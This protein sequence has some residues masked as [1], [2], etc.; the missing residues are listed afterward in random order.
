MSPSLTV[1]PLM[2]VLL[3]FIF[4]LGCYLTPLLAGLLPSG[5][6][7]GASVPSSTSLDPSSKGGPTATSKGSVPSSSGALPNVDKSEAK[8]ERRTVS[9]RG[10]GV[11]RL[12][13]EQREE[14]VYLP[15]TFICPENG[16]RYAIRQVPGDGGCLF[17]A[18][19][20]AM[21]F[22]K[23]RKH[24]AFD[25]KTRHMS[26]KLR[27]LSVL[28]LK[29][30][31][32]SL[33]IE[34]GECTT[35]S[36]LLRI[37]SEHYNMSQAEYCEQMLLSSS[38]GG[39]PEIVALCNHLQRPIYVFELCRHD[40]GVGGNSEIEQCPENACKLFDL[41]ICG[42]FGSP[43]FDDEKPLKILCADGRFPNSLDVDE[44]K[45]G[46]HF[47]ALETIE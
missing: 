6:L 19:T 40:N 29:R 24:V 31:D 9:R 38:W 28:L 20:V 32:V 26:D 46:D 2:R 3:V 25:E 45:P 23:T 44:T 12:G 10:I 42:K 16:E 34:N 18:L 15:G 37:V 27:K 5:V 7:L 8:Q 1:R 11:S 13:Q 35:S 41:R 47:L 43:Q 30:R 21:I 4:T 17:H 36:D 39:G 22:E 33:F 14:D